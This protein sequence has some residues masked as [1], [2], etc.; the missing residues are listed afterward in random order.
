[1][2]STVTTK[3]QITIP[4]NIRSF[5]HIQPNDKVDFVIDNGR[6][7]ITPIK[8]LKQL[9]GSVNLSG[10]GDITS[11]RQ[12]AKQALAGRISEELK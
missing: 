7:I 8:T 6:I 9:R 10:M 12:Q 4:V 1:M 3:G 5:F 11:E 2:V